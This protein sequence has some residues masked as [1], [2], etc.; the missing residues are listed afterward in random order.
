MPPP[1]DYDHLE[2]D[3]SDYV[4]ANS[5]SSKRIIVPKPVPLNPLVPVAGLG[6]AFVEFASASD[7]AKML[8]LISGKRYGDRT[9]FGSFY[10]LERFVKDDI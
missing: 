6:K 3:L 2:E 8:R 7:C 4:S 9:V 1:S 10:P 5:L